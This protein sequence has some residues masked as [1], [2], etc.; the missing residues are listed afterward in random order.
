MLSRRAWILTLAWLAF[1]QLARAEGPRLEIQEQ[2]LGPGGTQDLLWTADPENPSYTAFDVI[3]G[4]LD[5]LRGSSGD[6]IAATTGCLVNDGGSPL[7]SLP[8]PA[9]GRKIFF[10]VRAQETVSACGV[11]SWNESFAV[12]PFTQ[13]ADRDPWIAS[14]ATC[15]CP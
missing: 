4:D 13:P 5:L 10:L 3:Y 14:A 6:F 12:A 9:T 2:G 8:L 7:V 15:P 11:G 1:P